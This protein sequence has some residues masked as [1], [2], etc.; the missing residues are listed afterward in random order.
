MHKFKYF[1]LCTYIILGVFSTRAQ[2]ILDYFPDINII[3]SNGPSKGYFFAATKSFYTENGSNYF[4]IF[5]NDGTPVYMRL[6]EGSASCI[7]EQSNG[8]L[9]LIDGSIG[10]V[11]F[12][13]NNLFQ[14]VDSFQVEGYNTDGHD[15]DMDENG[16]VLL[17]GKEQ[18]FI[19][20][21]AIVNGGNPNAVVSDIIVQEF[22][23]DNKLLYTWK[24]WDH[25][26]ILDSN[27]NSPLVNLTASKVDYIHANS[28]CFDS[29]TSFLFSARHYN[30][31]TK[32]DRRTGDVIWR[33][34][35]KKNE[36]TF[37]NDEIR[38]SHQHTIRKLSNGN[39][40]FFD[41]GNMNNIQ[42]S[43]VVE[44]HIDDEN[45]TAT[46]IKRIRH[47]P[48]IYISKQ[49]GQKLLDN[50]NLLVHWGSDEPSFTEFNPDGSIALEMDFSTHSFSN[51][52]LKSVWKHKVFEIN[53]DH[54]DFG[55]WD[56]NTPI[57]KILDIKNNTDSTFT[58][59]GYHTKTNHFNIT[60][61]FPINIPAGGEIQLRVVY[62]PISNE[63][64]FIKDIIT[65]QAE[66]PDVYFAQ[67]VRLS[68]TLNDNISPIAKITPDSSR[69]DINAKI[70][71][72]FTEAVRFNDGFELNYQ[73]VDDIISFRKDNEQ[74]ELIAYDANVNT[75]KN[76]I[77]LTPL[78]PLEYD[79][80]YF[81]S[82][83]D[84]FEDYSNNKVNGV[85]HSFNTGFLT[86]T[87]TL[88]N[89]Q[90]EFRILPNPTNGKCQLVL[91]QEGDYQIIIM[92]MN[93]NIVAKH[94]I[95]M[96]NHTSLDLSSY[97]SGIY[98]V[99]IYSKGV[100]L[101]KQKLVKN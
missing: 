80:E 76:C 29:D 83:G 13:L 30:E 88:D 11:F 73:N 26:D 54:L 95:W 31:I 69:V 42:E 78:L 14:V 100:L 89:S 28:L 93:S 27:T 32:V 68:G 43:S 38:F 12:E 51:R 85:S 94:N 74:G 86:A 49:G 33:L 18:L 8:H 46:L 59:S 10:K 16:H 45:M 87:N 34:G 7:Q 25:F 52:I 50:G 67:Q 75:E 99:L 77:T 57:S 70:K 92:N 40:Q 55:M 41:N 96:A 81:V 15:F 5:D 20:M 84:L 97:P 61:S 6:L 62:S 101:D 24:A 19:D 64:G 91:A 35:G 3:E 47:I 9:T 90:N 2:S 82:F 1:L 37:V 39:I 58:L 21:S 71:I 23:A 56:G 53:T 66:Y 17:L 48:S 63:T 4:A 22:D 98:L 44:Y 36:F 79:R 60:E 72:S 65:I